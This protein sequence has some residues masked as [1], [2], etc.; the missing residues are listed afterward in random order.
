[1]ETDFEMVFVTGKLLS[2]V[3]IIL[4]VVLSSYCSSQLGVTRKQTQIIME[5]CIDNIYDAS[6]KSWQSC[7]LV[8]TSR[9]FICL[10]IQISASGV[11]NIGSQHVIVH[12]VVN[13]KIIQDPFAFSPSP[14]SKTV[15][16]IEEKRRKSEE[17]EKIR[18][19]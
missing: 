1:M 7:L 14:C 5:T 2:H 4:C 13:S 17:W 10:F 8:N 16:C 18:R 15:N 6:R 9:T 11:V 19:V 3:Y 12:D